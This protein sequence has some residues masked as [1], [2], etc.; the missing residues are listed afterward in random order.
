MRFSDAD[1]M[2]DEV[3]FILDNSRLRI[4]STEHVLG[5]NFLLHEVLADTSGL[6]LDDEL[7]ANKRLSGS[8]AKAL[9]DYLV[10]IDPAN[11]TAWATIILSDASRANEFVTISLSRL[12]TDLPITDWGNPNLREPA[13][14]A[15]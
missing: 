1:V 7:R 14:L 15:P 5:H 12:E 13:F 9:Y 2:R 4:G 6:N 11:V 3:Q 10:S 8:S